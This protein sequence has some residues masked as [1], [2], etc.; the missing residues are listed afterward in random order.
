MKL[1]PVRGEATMG[2]PFE[3]AFDIQTVTS[4]EWEPRSIMAG[5]KHQGELISATIDVSMRNEKRLDVHSISCE[6]LNS[7]LTATFKRQ[8]D[9]RG[10]LE[11]V[12]YANKLGDTEMNF[13]VQIYQE[14]LQEPIVLS[15]PI[16]YY[17]I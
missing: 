6:P 14:E 2:N 13:S 7:G 3:L 5:V 1:I 12:G 17:G 15:V 8:A 9:S 10:Y 11:I 16:H 4:L